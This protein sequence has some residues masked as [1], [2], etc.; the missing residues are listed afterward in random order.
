MERVACQCNTMMEPKASW[1]SVIYPRDDKVLFKP[2]NNK[3][4]IKTNKIVKF[5]EVKKKKDQVKI[6]K[7][8]MTQ[9][10]SYI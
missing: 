8:W 5:R 9:S 10:K 6:I 3:I 2:E 1:E 7:A 4:H